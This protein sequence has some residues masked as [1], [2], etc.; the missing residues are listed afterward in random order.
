MSEFSCGIV[1][2]SRTTNRDYGWLVGS[3]LLSKSEHA[4]LKRVFDLLSARR[5]EVSQSVNKPVFCIK[6]AR[7]MAVVAFGTSGVSDM[8]ARKIRYLQGYCS[9]TSDGFNGAELQSI[10]SDLQ[11]DKM[12]WDSDSIGGFERLAKNASPIQGSAEIKLVDGIDLDDGV[13]GDGA[14]T[15]QT[16]FDD[17]G[18][19]TLTSK[20]GEVTTFAFGATPEIALD[21]Q[22]YGLFDLV[23]PITFYSIAE[24][25]V[26]IDIGKKGG[27]LSAFAPIRCN[28]KLEYEG[29]AVHHSEIALQNKNLQQYYGTYSDN[30]SIK[31][32]LAASSEIKLGYDEFADYCRSKFQCYRSADYSVFIS[33]QSNL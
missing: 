32:L 28:F 12:V 21:L 16:T 22:S 13:K 15:I 9:L 25:R 6:F 27:V 1:L 24:G 5:Q 14:E 7:T 2:Y 18:Y 31:N 19:K 4:S 29:K 17:K 11:S 8:Q 10:L 20:L 33:A 30:A 26:T 3:S 23:A